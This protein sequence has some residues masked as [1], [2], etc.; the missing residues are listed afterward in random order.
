MHIE[1]LFVAM[2]NIFNMK[3]TK[4]FKPN[5]L[6]PFGFQ[7]IIVALAIFSFAVAK[8]IQG[9]IESFKTY[10]FYTLLLLIPCFLGWIISFF[11]KP[12]FVLRENSFS[13]NYGFVFCDD[14]TEIEIEWTWELFKHGFGWIGQ[15]H[16]SIIFYKGECP[17]AEVRF[18]SLRLLFY[19]LMRFKK[20]RIKGLLLACCAVFGF[21]LLGFIMGF[22]I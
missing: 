14:V 10:I 11:S 21:A 22:S 19:V 15:W 18:F 13:A 4:N 8:I 9:D 20:V 6:T 3:K 17:V 2:Y 1:F 7:L 12:H 16:N 5:Y